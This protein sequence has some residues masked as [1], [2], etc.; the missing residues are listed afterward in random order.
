[1]YR[2]SLE[3]GRCSMEDI[4]GL[5]ADAG[6]T[7]INSGAGVPGL[8]LMLARTDKPIPAKKPRIFPFPRIPSTSPCAQY[9]NRATR[10]IVQRVKRFR[11]YSRI[12]SILLESSTWRRGV[13]L[14]YSCVHVEL[15]VKEP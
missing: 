8:K 14:G 5:G 1:M 10:T 12:T 3:S 6:A 15:L 11:T 7:G 13:Y 2:S 4:A 9:A